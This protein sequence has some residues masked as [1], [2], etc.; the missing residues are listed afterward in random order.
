MEAEVS[1]LGVCFFSGR[2][3]YSV[4]EKGSNDTVQQLGSYE[5]LH[6]C[7]LALGFEKMQKGSLASALKDRESPLGPHMRRMVDLEG[8]NKKSPWAPQIF[9]NAGIEHMKK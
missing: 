3:L 2:M 8:L 5:G 7:C 4:A 1:N 6:D 9:G